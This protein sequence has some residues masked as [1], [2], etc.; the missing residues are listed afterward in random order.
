M[1]D[2]KS[3]RPTGSFTQAERPGYC[4]RARDDAQSAE[5]DEMDAEVAAAGGIIRKWVQTS[6]EIGGGRVAPRASSVHYWYELP[7]SA[8]A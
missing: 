4:V 3:L 1:A 2:L 7:E 5:R 6:N 8:V